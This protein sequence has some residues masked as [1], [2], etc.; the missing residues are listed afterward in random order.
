MQRVKRYILMFV[1]VWVAAV[2]VRAQVQVVVELEQNQ[3]LPGESLWVAA[4][5]INY[6]GQTL[7]LGQGNDWLQFMIETPEGIPVSCRATVPVE[8]PFELPSSK[9]ATKRLDVTPYYDFEQPKRYLLTAT[10]RIPAWGQEVRSK[11]ESFE[12]VRG[13]TL[14]QQ[15]V[16]LPVPGGES[17]P[18]EVR[19][20]ILQQALHIKQMKLYAR[21]TD[22]SGTRIHGTLPLGPMLSVSDPEKQI[23]A[24]TRLHVL[25][26]TGARDFTYCI[27]GPDGKLVRR[28]THEFT[29]SRPLL[30]RDREGQLRIIGG[31][32]RPAANDFSG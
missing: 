13:S 11:P 3:V 32:R 24:Q 22:A 21:V 8:E 2:W 12:V 18:P 23:D 7:S 9:M 1:A 19:R 17:R 26:Q 14:W 20:F 10:V 27:V 4:R 29:D 15:D 6:S 31:M 30:R 5:V 28:E 16:G 25:W